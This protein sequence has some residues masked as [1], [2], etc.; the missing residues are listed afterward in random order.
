MHLIPRKGQTPRR[1]CIWVT[2]LYHC[3]TALLRGGGLEKDAAEAG[4]GGQSFTREVF[5]VYLSLEQKLPGAGTG[6]G[7]SDF[8]V[9]PEPIQGKVYPPFGIYREVYI[10]RAGE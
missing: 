7:S 10:E 8:H 3:T 6:A 9:S 2:F 1:V 5:L 4:S